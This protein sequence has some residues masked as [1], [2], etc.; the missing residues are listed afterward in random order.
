MQ[1]ALNGPMTADNELKAKE[2]ANLIEI[3]L[4][5]EEVYW[6]HRS[7]ANWLQHG[8]RNTS[9]FDN[10][11][12]ARRKKKFINKL[13]NDLGDWVEGT[14]TLKPLIHD[15]FSNLF[16]SEVQQCDPVALNKIHRKVTQEMNEKLAAP[17]T[18]EEVRK[19]MF[20]IGDFKAPGPDSL[21]AIF[22]KSFG[23]K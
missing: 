20:S 2:N 5:Q 6:S 9:Y 15:Y 16:T 11:A 12:S 4:E 7:R 21:H 18:A 10:F 3:L 1:E 8:D 17:F 22:T 23:M 19:A 13:K 14:D